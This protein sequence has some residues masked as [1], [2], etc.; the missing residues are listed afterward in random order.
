MISNI[1]TMSN[2]KSFYSKCLTTNA[3]YANMPE[4]STTSPFMVPCEDT[5]VD[6]D[7]LKYWD[8]VLTL[9][10]QGLNWVAMV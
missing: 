8:K 7:T 4:A 10:N 6:I 3:A 5:I 2:T 9:Y 1:V